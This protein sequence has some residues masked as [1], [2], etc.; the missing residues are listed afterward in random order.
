MVDL[1]C[2]YPT[3][4]NNER[5]KGEIWRKRSKKIIQKGKTGKRKG[6][7]R[8]ERGERI[9]AQK[10]KILALEDVTARIIATYRRYRRYTF[11]IE[12]EMGEKIV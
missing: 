4:E 5:R 11:I 1:R 3:T 2:A 12:N 6:R 9:T 7:K 10:F 8:G